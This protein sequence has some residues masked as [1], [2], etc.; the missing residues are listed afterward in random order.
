MLNQQET[1]SHNTDKIV[2][3]SDGTINNQ[4][5]ID[6]VNF[7]NHKNN[8]L[9]N[10]KIVINNDIVNN[11]SALDI[12]NL[13]KNQQILNEAILNNQNMVNQKVVINNAESG[14]VTQRIDMI[15]N[16]PASTNQIIINNNGTLINTTGGSLD[17]KELLQTQKLQ[18]IHTTQESGK[19]HVVVNENNIYDASGKLVKTEDLTNKLILN[20]VANNQKSPDQQVN[21]QRTK[22]ERTKKTFNDVYTEHLQQQVPTS[23]YNSFSLEQKQGNMIYISE[24]GQQHSLQSQQSQNKVRHSLLW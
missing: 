5:G 2:I 1:K 20:N 4:P 6:L 21:G 8:L 16:L 22:Q 24:S 10:Q 15:K 17:L 3:N 14:L 13:Q 11:Q 19:N 18:V 23:Q 7:Q 9:A 12:I